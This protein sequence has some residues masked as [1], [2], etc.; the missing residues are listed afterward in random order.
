MKC[1]YENDVGYCIEGNKCVDFCEF[2][3]VNIKSIYVIILEK[4]E[5][6]KK[7]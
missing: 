1:L 6:W 4:N 5:I 7:L 2:Y 3:K